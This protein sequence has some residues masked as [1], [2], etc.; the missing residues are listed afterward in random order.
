MARHHL[1]I[2]GGERVDADA[3]TEVRSPYDGRVLGTVPTGTTEHLDAAVTAARQTLNAGTLPTHE[4]AAILDRLAVTLFDR[5]EEFAQSISTEAAK[6]IATARGEA[7]RAVDTARFSAAVARTLGGDVITMDA[8]SAGDGKTC[9][10][11]TSPS[12]R[13]S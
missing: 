9:L 12:P 11:Y 4:R 13:D 2:I 7:A 6:P 3:A 1:M 5:A 10:L 8:S